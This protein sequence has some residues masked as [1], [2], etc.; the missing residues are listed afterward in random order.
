MI[1]Q[2][3]Q[4]KPIAG[5]TSKIPLSLSDAVG[6]L[7]ERGYPFKFRRDA[8]SLYC[9]ELDSWFP[10]NRFTIDE[11]Y[12]LDDYSILPE[13]TMLYAVSSIYGLKGFLIDI[14]FADAD[15]TDIGIIEGPEMEDMLLSELF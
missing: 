6:D 15:K 11:Y 12:P 13:G 3:E 1:R 4:F 14:Y 8:G 10:V 5:I 9:V 2:Q 7:R